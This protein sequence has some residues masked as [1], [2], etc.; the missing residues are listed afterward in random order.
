MGY[1]R[2]GGPA[3]DDEGDD[4]YES[5]KPVYKPAA[6]KEA[7]EPTSET[8]AKAPTVPETSIPTVQVEHPAIQSGEELRKLLTEVLARVSVL[9]GLKTG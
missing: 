4:G 5:D 6:K 7:D 2:I 8:V 3:S 9:V 1:A